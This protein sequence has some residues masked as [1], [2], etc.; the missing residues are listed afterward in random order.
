MGPVRTL[1][2]LPFGH[3]RVL[4]V[5]VWTPYGLCANI[6]IPDTEAPYCKTAVN[7]PHIAYRYV[8][9]MSGEAESYGISAGHMPVGSSLRH[10]P[11]TLHVTIAY[12][13]VF[14]LLG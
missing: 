8:T 4:K 12:R 11:Y 13:W 2:R 6:R 7:H 5:I 14:S 3:L 10:G 9:T 1:I